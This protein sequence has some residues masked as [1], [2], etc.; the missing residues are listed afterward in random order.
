MSP[1]IQ[2]GRAI[3]T[4]SPSPAEMHTYPMFVEIDLRTVD[5]KLTF[6][7]VPDNV[8]HQSVDED[9]IGLHSV[10]RHFDEDL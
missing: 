10:L 1:E 9:R 4:M 3:A 5:R 8:A 6:V 2:N 7:V